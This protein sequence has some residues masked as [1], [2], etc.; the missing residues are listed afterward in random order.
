MRV[1]IATRLRALENA[2]SP[3]CSRTL[4]GSPFH[5]Q[6]IYLSQRFP[7]SGFWKQFEIREDSNPVNIDPVWLRC[8]QQLYFSKRATTNGAQ[9]RVYLLRKN[10]HFFSILS[11][12][13]DDPGHV[14]LFRVLLWDF[15][16][17]LKSRGDPYIVYLLLLP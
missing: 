1:V 15:N 8:S 13:G 3:L 14:P 6:D 11:L 9:I 7:P 12:V 4:F 10:H 2:P 16:S 17:V 5:I